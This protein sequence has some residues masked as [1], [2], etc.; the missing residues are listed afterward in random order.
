MNAIDIGTLVWSG[1]SGLLRVGT[2]VSKRIAKN[3]WV[4]FTIE[5]HADETYQRTQDYYRSMN[6]NRE[7]GL[8]EY[9]ASFV[10]PVSPEH[11]ERI[12]SS[13]RDF[14]DQDDDSSTEYHHTLSPLDDVVD[15]LF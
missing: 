13:H 15:I 12:V 9:K 14:I 7:Y 8:K 6:P 1:Y 10:H 5:W 11:L 4:Y 2:V 3:G